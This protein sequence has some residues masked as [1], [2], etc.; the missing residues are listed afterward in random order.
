MPHL[1]DS[2]WWGDFVFKGSI[3]TLLAFGVFVI[4]LVLP[5]AV[6]P[7]AIA[8]AAGLYIL[9]TRPKVKR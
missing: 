7:P 3:F 2:N 5:L 6:L 1:P 4:A 8:G 9:L